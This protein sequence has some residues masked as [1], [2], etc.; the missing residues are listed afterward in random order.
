M[1]ETR[2]GSWETALAKA[3]LPMPTTPNKLTGFTRYVEETERQKIVYREKKAAKKQKA[4][5]R[6]KAQKEK[7]KA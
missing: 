6:L 4:Q 1:I 3:K 2:F 5:Q 7:Q